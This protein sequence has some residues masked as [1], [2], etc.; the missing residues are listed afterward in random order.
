LLSPAA[1]VMVAD[2]AMGGGQVV[3]NPALPR[4][5]MAAAAAAAVRRLPVPL[6]DIR[7]AREVRAS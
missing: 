2:R 6:R 1:V 4:P 5:V 3:R 7:V